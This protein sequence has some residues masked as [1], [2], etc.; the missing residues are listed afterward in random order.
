MR[1]WRAAITTAVAL[2]V[3]GAVQQGAAA[4]M[5]VFGVR[6]DILLTLTACLALLANRSKA[7]GA[8]FLA[9]LVQGSL[10]GANTAAYVISRSVAGFSASWSKVVGYEM[11]LPAVAIVT[12][13]T[14][15]LAEIVWMFLALRSGIAEFLGATIGTAVYNGVLAMPMYALLRRIIEPPRR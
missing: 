14:T 3:L 13:F 8:G 4:K 7:A 12:F 15:L 5:A 1:P 2:Y 10:A 11:R 9:G 6:P